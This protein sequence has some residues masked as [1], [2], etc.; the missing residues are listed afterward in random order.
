[1]HF[2]EVETVLAGL[3]RAGVGYWVAGGW[4]V[5]ALVGRQTREH[6]D[7]DLLVEATKLEGCLRVLEQLGYRRETDWL[8]V[9]V[10]YVADHRGWV[11]VHPVRFFDDGHGRQ[12]GLDGQHFDYP[13]DVWTVGRLEHRPVPCVSAAQQRAFHAGYELRAPDVH[14]LG[15]LGG[16]EGG[17]QA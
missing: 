17:G 5:A 8:P 9:R 2:E 1:V 3:E 4:G 15:L 16:L 14:D 11:D 12:E 10:E 6:R 7:L 13:P